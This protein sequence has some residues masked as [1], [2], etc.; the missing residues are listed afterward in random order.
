MSTTFFERHRATLDKAVQTIGER[1]YWSPYSESPSPRVYGETAADEGKAAYDARLNRPFEIDQTGTTGRTGN[2]VSPY[3]P[4][5]GITYPKADIDQLLQGVAAA[6][7]AWR[8]AGPQVWAG[9]ALEIVARLNA[10]SFEIAHAVMHTTGQAYMMS[11]QAGG[12]HAQDRAVE[13]IAYAWQETSRI[14]AGAH[15]EKP[16]GKHDPL[17]MQ[18]SFR[19]VPRGIGLVIGCCTFPTWNS[20]PGM[21]ADLATGNTVIVKPHPGAILPLA[22]TVEIARA[23]IAEAGF[24]PDVVTLVAHEAGDKVAT[25]LALRPEI[26]LIDFTG[27]SANGNWL[28]R[29]AVQAQVFTEKSGV[30]QIV[31]DSTADFKGMARNIAFS[32]VLYSGQMC[33]TP[34]NIYIP[35]DG[36]DTAEGHVSFDAV[37]AAIGEAIGKLTGD[38]VKAVELLGAIQNTAVLDRIEAARKVGEV[39]LDSVS[40]QH[41]QFPEAR[42]RTPLLVKA[43]GGKAVTEEFFGPISFAVA[44]DSTAESIKLAEKTVREHGALTLSAYTTDAAVK[45]ALGD[46]A[47]EAGVA[48]SLN[49]TGGV[50][51]NQSAAFSDFHGTGA[52][53]AANAALADTA[54]VASRFRVVQTREPV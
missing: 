38:P 11:F 19:I 14:P 13:A 44:S 10:R 32:L 46:A 52:N 54:F 33:T 9:V 20:Y 5:L 25:E 40:L 12:P 34:Q 48:L 47:A 29:N 45:E 22:I 16:Q 15:W 41:P 30:N 26:K 17:K 28:E 1:G 50:F 24:N 4:A 42:I 21:F 51:V 3:G 6:G 39:V 43:A 7:V 35:K 49:L 53:P 8:K 37:V 2:E 23:V 27:S 31:I 18:K 36:I